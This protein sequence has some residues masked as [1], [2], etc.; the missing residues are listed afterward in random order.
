MSEPVLDLLNKFEIPFKVS[1]KDFVI[2][3]LNPEHEDNNPSFR[4]DRLSGVAHCFS[5]GYKVN[6]FKHFGLLTNN[7]SIRVAKLKEKLKELFINF[8]GVD[9]PYDKVPLNKSIRGI[10]VQTLREFETFYT[11]GREDL[12]DRAIFPIRD[13]RNRIVAY[14]GR[15]ML[16]SGNPRYL[17]Y[18]S[19]AHLPI[20]PEQLKERSKNLILVEGIFDLLNLYDKGLKNVACTFGTG[21]LYKETAL[22]LLPFRTQGISKIYLMYDGDVAGQDAMD[23]LIPLIEEADYLVEKIKLPDDTDPGDLSQEDVNSIK[24]WI[25]TN[26]NSSN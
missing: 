3:C 18:P 9:F 4:I 6:I 2:K 12:V 7:N 25:K 23:K 20:F 21:T 17:I 24:D 10:S 15:H 22:K 14:I 5:C 11:H 16:S 13:I 8:N 19:G 26:E 1:G